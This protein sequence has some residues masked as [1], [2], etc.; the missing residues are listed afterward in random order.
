MADS[1]VTNQSPEL[2]GLL[3]DFRSPDHLLDAAKDL[4]DAGFQKMEAYTPFPVHG[5]QEDRKS[6]V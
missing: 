2:E 6:V 3:A 1:S 5:I 4:R